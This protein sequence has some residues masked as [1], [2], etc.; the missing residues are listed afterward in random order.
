MATQPKNNQLLKILPAKELKLLQPHLEVV[1][2]A[3]NQVLL[4]EGVIRHVFFPT[5]GIV[6]KIVKMTTGRQLEAGMIGKEGMIPLCLFLELDKTPFRAVVQNAGEAF[7][8]STKDFKAKIKLVPSLGTSLMRFAAAFTA[9]ASLSAACNQL[10][11]T[12]PRFCRWLLMTHDRIGENRFMLTQETAA[13]MLG[14]RRMSITA[15][16][17][18]LQEQ[19]LI[20]YSRGKVTIVDR[21]G[22][23]R[24]TCEC[25]ARIKT[26]YD[27]LLSPP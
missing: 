13:T 6:T 10:H 23:E 18:K 16:A 20:E 24:A 2:L 14:V 8:I 22:L 27:N 4:G 12:L 21:P 5:S 9:Q 3:R 1:P 17:I 15:A 7:R 11:Q 26:S 25:Y 19:G